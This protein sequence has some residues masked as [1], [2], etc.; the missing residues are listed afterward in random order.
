[1]RLLARFILRICG[2]K[3]VGNPPVDDKCVMIMAPHTSSSDFVWGR[4][5]FYAF[6]IP[7]KFLIKQEFFAFPIGGLM[8][9]LGGIP[10]NREQ[11]RNAV[12]YAIELFDRYDKIALTITPE[13]TR[14]YTDTWKKGFYFIAQHANVPIYIGFLDYKEKKGGIKA[15]FEITGDYEEDLKKLQSYFRGLHAKYPERFNL[16]EEEPTK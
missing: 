11:S 6:G 16:S 3:I 10:I 9:A 4:L 15:K 12:K 8:R 2:W 13:G 1:M 5:F 7:A 14:N